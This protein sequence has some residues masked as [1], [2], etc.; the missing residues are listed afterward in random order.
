MLFFYSEIGRMN[1]LN[2]ENT[3]QSSST[4]KDQTSE[5]STEYNKENITCPNKPKLLSDNTKVVFSSQ[6]EHSVKDK[7]DPT[8]ATSLSNRGDESVAT[9]ASSLGCVL[10]LARLFGRGNIAAFQHL[11]KLAL[12][13]GHIGVAMDMASRLSNEPLNSSECSGLSELMEGVLQLL[14]L[15]LQQL[16]VSQHTCVY[17][18]SKA[19]IYRLNLE[20]SYSNILI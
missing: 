12:D 7:T 3:K 15:Q 11:A 5:D 20:H 9:N 13:S 4:L 18:V 19:T 14:V 1:R 17:C 2:Y 10:E 8:A 6:K 16:Q